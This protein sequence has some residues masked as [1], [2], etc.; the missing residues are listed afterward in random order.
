MSAEE[1][2]NSPECK[3]AKQELAN[4]KKNVGHVGGGCG[5]KNT[6][7]T[8]RKD[9]STPGVQVMLFRQLMAQQRLRE[10]RDRRDLLCFGG[11]DDRHI[12]EN[13]NNV[14]A[15]QNCITALDSGE[16]KG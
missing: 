13:A 7:K 5:R 15:I 1:R 8:Q 3:A 4:A 2:E 6:T 11:P 12:R 9:W 10:A 16:F 14:R